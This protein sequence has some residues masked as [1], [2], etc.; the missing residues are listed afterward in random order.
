MKQLSDEE[1]LELALKD[2]EEG[3]PEDDISYYQHTRQIVDGNNKVYT[4]H[5]YFDYCKFS[6]DPV[7]LRYFHDKIK[8]T[9]KTKTCLFV[10]KALC[11]I[12]LDRLLGDY[13]R[14]KKAVKKEKGLR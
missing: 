5:L 7:N 1:L 3:L 8:I 4:H 12:D 6:N 2:L 11:S 13:V 9:K 14:E 10:N